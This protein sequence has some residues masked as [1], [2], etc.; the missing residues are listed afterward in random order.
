VARFFEERR[1]QNGTNRYAH[2]TDG[3]IPLFFEKTRN[4]MRRLANGVQLSKMQENIGNFRLFGK[5]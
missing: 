4:R 3:D 2:P 1:A 5:S